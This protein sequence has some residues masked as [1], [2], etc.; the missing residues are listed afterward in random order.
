MGCRPFNVKKEIRILGVSE[1]KNFKFEDGV[2]ILPD[3]ISM[4]I[5]VVF[6]GGL[7]LDGVM[8]TEITLGGTDSTERIV[9]MVKGSRHYGQLRLMMLDG[10]IY[11]DGNI[12]DM[13]RLFKETSIPVIAIY[14]EK[15]DVKAFEELLRKLPQRGLHEKALKEAGQIYRVGL[16]N[17]K[18][19]LFMQVVGISEEEALSIIKASTVRPPLPEPIIV[20][21]MVSMGL[22]KVISR[23][24]SKNNRK[25]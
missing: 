9:N 8:K 24:T 11:A 15:P 16:Q 23:Y 25:E 12:V 17:R 6:R 21:R 7:W 13:C 19:E 3:G 20:S 22:A 10:V 18:V 1:V 14:E 5:G 4:L 2:G